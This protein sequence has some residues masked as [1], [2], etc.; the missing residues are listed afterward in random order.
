MRDNIRDKEYFD[1]FIEEEL[2]GIQMFEESIADGEIEE[3]RIDYIK[4]EII[5]FDIRHTQYRLAG[6]GISKG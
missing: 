2:E 3:D 1:V 4:D 5:P 6:N